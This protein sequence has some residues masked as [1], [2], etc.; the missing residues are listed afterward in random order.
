MAVDTA[1]PLA[2]DDYF[3]KHILQK[4]NTSGPRYTSYPT[5]V[6]FTEN[7]NNNEDDVAYELLANSE[8]ADSVSIYIHIPFC[9]KLCYYCGCNKI[10]T[11]HHDK[12]DLYLDY[13]HK[14]F[15]LKSSSLK[16][17]TIKDVHLGGGTP[18]FLTIAQMKRLKDML[19]AYFTFA[20]N[21]EFSIEL[22]PRTVTLDYLTR[23]YALGF[24]RVSFGIQDAN[25]K[26]QEAINRTQDSA[27]IKKLIAHAKKLG[28]DSVNLDLIYGLPHQNESTFEE[29]L[30]L[31][32]DISPDRVSLFSYAH[33]PQM[34]AAQRKIKDDWL[35]SAT[36]K[37]ALFRQA[38]AFMNA[39]G[40]EFIGMDHFAKTDDKLSI[41]H[42]NKT[43]YRNFQGYTTGIA[44]ACIGFGC[45][46]ISSIGH[47][48]Q[49]NAKSLN[50]YYAMLDQ[51]TLPIV[52]G[53][54]LNQDD[55]IRRDLI[56]TLM[57]N[58]EVDKTKFGKKHS[59]DFDTYF[60][61]ELETLES[62]QQDKLL[63]DNA[64]KIIVHDRGRLIVR[65]ICMSFDQYLAQPMHQM[66]YSRVI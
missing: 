58:F 63:T 50:D 13:L 14:E 57:C 34:F 29:T 65:N 1:R 5:A 39:L 27:H 15:L 40:Y 2:L 42:R 48:Y 25:H 28:F 30:Q 20:D 54:V 17:C 10:V 22:D 37:F 9:H 11:R 49:Q 31:V 56:H 47:I 6:A 59:I 64:E 53:V 51:N 46:S 52:K 66:R 32:E 16:G 41:A 26:V 23:L 12:A 3:D 55:V 24:T 44:N 60:Q 38:I 4:Y 8:N 33:M 35:P 21:A 62:M 19:N 7:Y 18:N 61:S 36:A 43:L 45:S